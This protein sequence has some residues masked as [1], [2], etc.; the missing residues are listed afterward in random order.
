MDN[1]IKFILLVAL[2]I[3]T[4]TGCTSQRGIISP[5][6]IIFP[7]NYN[8]TVISKD[9]TH[10]LITHNG[11]VEVIEGIVISNTFY[12]GATAQDFF[13][14]TLIASYDFSEMERKESS[15]FICFSKCYYTN[16]DI[17]PDEFAVLC[18]DKNNELVLTTRKT[19]GGSNLWIQKGITIPNNM[20]CSMGKITKDGI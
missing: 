10:R 14:R 12:I 19:D 9:W 7:G 16:E 6:D 2:L 5:D 3:V 15:D 17:V 1:S 4:L 13:A 20:T 18:I 8:A 11:S